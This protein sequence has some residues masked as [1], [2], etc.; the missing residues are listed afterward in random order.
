MEAAGGTKL[1][2]IWIGP[3]G[4]AGR[5]PLRSM[6]PWMSPGEES[7][8]VASS[9]ARAASGGAGREVSAGCLGRPV[10]RLRGRVVLCTMGGVGGV[11]GPEREGKK[12]T[13]GTTGDGPSSTSGCG[14]GDP[15]SRWTALMEG[16]IGGD[17]GGDQKTTPVPWS[18]D[19]RRDGHRVR[20]R[21][22]RPRGRRT[23]RGSCR[24]RPARDGI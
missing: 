18:M 22:H 23:R 5:L 1:R 11:S 21:Q 6:G 24:G 15:P 13:G 20:G 16:L 9:T 12:D 10:G 3:R 2:R 8:E 4:V 7:A 14:S 17:G 19:L